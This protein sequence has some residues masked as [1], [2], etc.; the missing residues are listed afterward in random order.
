M[1]TQDIE[2]MP[3]LQDSAPPKRRPAA[4]VPTKKVAVPVRP[5][6]GAD[7]PVPFDDDPPPEIQETPESQESSDS[8]TPGTGKEISEKQRTRLWAISRGTGWSDDDLK[9]WLYNFHGYKSSKDIQYG[10]GPHEYT[11][12]CTELQQIGEAG[13]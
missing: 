7:P 3:H 12:I 9:D 13:I 4:P 10:D 8:L 2:D 6:E 5:E 1:F 11:A